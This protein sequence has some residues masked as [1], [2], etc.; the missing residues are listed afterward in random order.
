ML[1]F[2]D[3]NLKGAVVIL[4][5]AQVPI[6]NIS[7]SLATTL[8]VTLMIIY[9]IVSLGGARRY[10]STIAVIVESSALYSTALIIYIPFVLSLKFSDR[11]PNAVLAQVAVGPIFEGFA[12]YDN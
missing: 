10:H 1:F 2:L 5:A 7:L 12:R 3:I 11:I 6:A 8:L 4:E 9:R